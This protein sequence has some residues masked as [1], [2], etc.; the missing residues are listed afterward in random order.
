MKIV[1]P[2]YWYLFFLLSFATTTAYCTEL[3]ERKIVKEQAELAYSAKDFAGL[4]RQFILYCDFKN[5][6]TSSG[7]FKINLFYDGIS[8]AR[9]KLQINDISKDIEV[10]KNWAEKN[11]DLLF[12]QLLYAEALQS[13][14]GR[15]RGEGYAN[16][17]SPERWKIFHELSQKAM[18]VKV[19]SKRLAG[20]NAVW[21]SSMIGTAR[22]V[23]LPETSVKQLLDSGLKENPFNWILYTTS[24]EYYLPKWHGSPESMDRFI[25]YAV[26]SAPDE[27]GEELYARLYSGAEQSQFRRTLYLD[28][29]VNWKRMKS[30]LD[31][32]VK[33]FP[34]SWNR[35]IFAYHACIAGDKE[36]FRQLYEQIGNQPDL[37]IWEP[38]PQTTFSA[39]VK[40]ASRP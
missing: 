24:L 28:S 12:A 33:R 3:D 35:N 40:W 27:Y 17:V 13:F 18:Q 34:T 21:Q 39:C 20:K 31:L 38:R 4:N 23:N 8:D 6:R 22:L 29:H 14:A 19:N 16:T 11:K 5:Q 7:A 32:W 1:H 36:A 2:S 9:K 37:E 25:Q 26:T 30:G 10:T 15:I